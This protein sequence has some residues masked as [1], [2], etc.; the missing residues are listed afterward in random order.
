MK[1]WI[2]AVAALAVPAHASAQ[3]AIRIEPNEA[4]QC[5]VWASALSEFVPDEETKVGLLYALSYFVGQYEG[6]S[7]RSIKDGHDE[8][9]ITE[10]ARYPDAFTARCQGHMAQYGARMIEWGT[11]LSELGQRLVAEEAKQ[12]PAN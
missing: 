6:A 2:V 4:M 11:T 7:G 9:L 8:A 3:E 12:Q 1:R 5:A 10:V